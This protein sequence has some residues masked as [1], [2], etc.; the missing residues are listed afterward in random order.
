V[1]SE[2]ADEIQ[3][4]TKYTAVRY[5]ILVLVESTQPLVVLVKQ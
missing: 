3:L 1:K 4:G 5:P 2:Q